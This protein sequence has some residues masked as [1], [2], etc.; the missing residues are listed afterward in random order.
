MTLTIELFSNLLQLLVGGVTTCALAITAVQKKKLL[1]VLA[2]GMI[3]SLFLGILYWSTY[4][5]IIGSTPEIFQVADFSWMAA[6]L[7]LLA[8]EITLTTAQS[9]EN[10]YLPSYLPFPIAITL[11]L[12]FCQWGGVFMNVA[13][14]GLLAF[15][16]HY[17]VRNL[18]FGTAEYRPIHQFCIAFVAVEYS[19][20]LS[21]CFWVSDTLTNPYFWFDFALTALMGLF[22]VLVKKVAANDLY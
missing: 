4:Q 2:A 16:A 11:I 3:G 6:Y 1:Y 19:L 15:C 9:K 14:V 22:Y 5:A 7:F 20:W 13:H 21:S 17:A 10:R 8:L 12:Y 18:R